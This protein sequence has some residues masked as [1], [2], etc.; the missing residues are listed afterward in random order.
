[1]FVTRILKTYVLFLI[2]LLSSLPVQA[3]QSAC[4]VLKAAGAGEMRTRFVCAQ[5]A[6]THGF[7][8]SP[9][10]VFAYVFGVLLVMFLVQRA[11]R[12]ARQKSAQSGAEKGSG[13]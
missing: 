3:E 6:L 11:A 9:A 10:V 8:N 5:D 2:S 12:P 4:A 13:K 1:M 7:L